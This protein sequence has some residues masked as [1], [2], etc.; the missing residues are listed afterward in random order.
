MGV[1]FYGFPFLFFSI[2]IQDFG[3]SFLE[4]IQEIFGHTNFQ[5]F[6]SGQANGHSGGGI[7]III[8]QNLIIKKPLHFLSYRST[9]EQSNL[10]HASKM[11]KH[12][13]TRAIIEKSYFQRGKNKP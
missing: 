5:F 11:T 10:L 1:L 4:N 13:L 6:G 12:Y 2:F 8:K 3:A 9:N 7:N